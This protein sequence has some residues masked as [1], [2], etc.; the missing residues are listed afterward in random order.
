MTR[1]AGGNT[2]IIRSFSRSKMKPNMG[3]ASRSAGPCPA[4]KTLLESWGIA[5]DAGIVA[6]EDFSNV[7]PA[8]HW[9]REPRVRM[10]A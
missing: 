1:R 8:R 3:D 2:G 9:D 10:L 7:A 4:T 5:A 6:I